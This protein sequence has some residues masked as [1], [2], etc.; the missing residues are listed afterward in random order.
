MPQVTP[1]GNW[2]TRVPVQIHLLV[3]QMAVPGGPSNWIVE[4]AEWEACL[5]YLLARA[6]YAA[7]T[8]ASEFPTETLSRYLDS[9][10]VHLA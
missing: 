9:P 3:Q 1:S 6:R 5:D 10:D 8:D 4:Y 2:G 7:Y